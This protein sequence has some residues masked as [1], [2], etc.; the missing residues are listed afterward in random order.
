MEGK[1]E[2]KK[3]KKQKKMSKNLHVENNVAYF[4]SPSVPLGDKRTFVKSKKNF[5]QFGKV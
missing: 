3:N 5:L 1:K 4:L 2:R